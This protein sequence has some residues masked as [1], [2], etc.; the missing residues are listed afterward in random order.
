MRHARPLLLLIV[1]LALAVPTL[2]QAQNQQAKLVGYAQMPANLL[3]D[4]PAAGKALAAQGTTINGIKVAFDSQ[5]VGS[6]VGIAPA[7]PD[8]WLAL[9]ESRFDTSP[10][11]ADYLLRIYTT[12]PDLHVAGGGS[13][14]VSLLT[15]KTLSDP[16]KKLK[17]LKD[18]SA[19][20]NLSGADFRPRAFVMAKDGT[21]WIAEA[22]GPSLLHVNADG[23]L[24]DVPIALPPGALQGISVYP[25]DQTLIIAQQATGKISFRTFDISG[26]ALSAQPIAATYPLSNP[27]YVSGMAMI[28]TSEAVLIEQDGKDAAQFKQVFLFNLDSGQKTPLIDLLKIGDPN[29]LAGPNAVYSFPYLDVAA[30][31]PSDKQ[32]FTLVNNN[33]VPFSKVRSANA[34]PTEFLV[35]QVAQPINIDSGYYQLLH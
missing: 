4:G 10:N 25:D 15:W 29:H 26:K 6:I 18:T 24:L 35:V 22:N 13:G 21:F 33:R 5:P 19:S 27:N 9:T 11:S 14:Q 20:R 7:G 31:Y 1:G 16:S 3:A 12:Q 17:Q 8:T 28:N 34:D 2:V 30:I 23:K 32:T